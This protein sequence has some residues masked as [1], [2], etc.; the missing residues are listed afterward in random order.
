MQRKSLTLALA[1]AGTIGLA[2]A[3]PG[4]ARDTGAGTN[5]R[6]GSGAAAQT[7]TTTHSETRPMGAM[8]TPPMRNGSTTSTPRMN[9]GPSGMAPGGQSFDKMGR[10]TW[11]DRHA[12]QN[13]GR[14]SRE[15]YMDEMS[16][17][18]DA[19]DPN[20]RGL[21]PAEVSRLYGNVDSAAGPGHTGSG[22]PTGNM[23]PGSPKAQ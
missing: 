23:G 2:T 21:T 3:M 16:R 22:V 6:T 20:D 18:W 13:K 7:A 14:I 17:R 9:E 4:F 12:E 15:A 11:A 10:D 19:M 1:I 8:D 5:D